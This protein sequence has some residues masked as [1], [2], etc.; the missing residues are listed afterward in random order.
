MQ[1]DPDRIRQALH[2]LLSNAITHTPDSVPI[3]IGAG[4]EVRNDAR[5][6]VIT[7]HDEGP[8]IPSRLMDGLFARFTSAPSSPGLG[9]GL[10]LAREIVEAHD[11]TVS[12]ESTLGKGTSFWVSLPLDAQNS[13]GAES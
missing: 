1:V 3:L 12:V 6:A 11:G 8:G 4:T 2:N 10:Y 5:W 9:I 7:V 13:K